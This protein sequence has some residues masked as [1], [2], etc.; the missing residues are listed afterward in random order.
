MTISDVIHVITD[1]IGDVIATDVIST[2]VA[3]RRDVV[4]NQPM[5]DYGTSMRRKQKYV[6]VPIMNQI[7]YQAAHQ[8]DRVVCVC[9]G[10]CRYRQIRL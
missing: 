10:G 5:T 6:L 3:V 8:A 9:G 1:V 2:G 4:W 7:V